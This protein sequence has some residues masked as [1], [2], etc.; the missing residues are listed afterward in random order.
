MNL[1]AFAALF[2]VLPLV[3]SSNVQIIDLTEDDSSDYLAP[4]ASINTSSLSTTTAASNL[5]KSIV[6][7]VRDEEEASF[8]LHYIAQ[9]LLSFQIKDLSDRLDNLRTRELFKSLRSGCNWNLLH[10][11][12]QTDNVEVAQLLIQKFKFDPNVFDPLFGNCVYLVQSC[13]MVQMLLNNGADFTIKEPC[14]AYSNPEEAGKLRN[15]VAYYCSQDKALTAARYDNFVERLVALQAANRRQE[16]KGS[17]AA[18]YGIIRHALNNFPSS[19]PPNA[20]LKVSYSEEIGIDDGGL[21]IDL[22]TSIKNTIIEQRNILL[23]DTETGFVDFH[24][25]ATGSDAKLVGFLV[26]LSIYHKVP[27]NL[28]F[29]PIFYHLICAQT[30]HHDINFVSVLRE[31]SQEM[32]TSFEVIKGNSDE[33]LGQIEF[34]EIDE[35]NNDEMRLK[36]RRNF[37]G[38]RDNIAE[39]IKICS[40][41]LVY[42]KRAEL[43]DNFLVGVSCAID[44]SSIGLF[45]NP[46]DIKSMIKGQIDYTATQLKTSSTLVHIDIFPYHYAWFFEIVSEMTDIQRGKLLNFLTALECLPIDGFKNFSHPIKIEILA[47]LERPDERIPEASTCVN[48]LYLHFYSSKEVM[49]SKLIYAIEETIGFYRA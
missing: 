47:E 25:G 28:I 35:N 8:D 11:A 33:I 15:N 29:N 9:N 32:Y 24:L 14:L 30:P 10:E 40:K 1:L 4:I 46:D 19:R 34:P 16:I 42:D 21:T 39:Y 2:H 17:N 12:V 38:S 23:T 20:K 13:R 44:R 41:Q 3:F 5:P 27:L 37:I 36:R 22:I 48:T 7:S 18:M 49:K 6:F 26:G 31:T 43:Y 45:L